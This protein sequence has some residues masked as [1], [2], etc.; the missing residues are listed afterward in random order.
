MVRLRGEEA[1]YGDAPTQPNFNQIPNIDFVRIMDKVSSKGVRQKR[2]VLVG[3]GVLILCRDN[4]FHVK[5]I[6][7]VQDIKGVFRQARP[8]KKDVGKTEM[9]VLLC[10]P[11][12]GPDILLYHPNERKSGYASPVDMTE[13]LRAL[14]F[15]K[16]FFNEQLPIKTLQEDGTDHI[17]SHAYLLK[18]QEY[19]PPSSH[20][21]DLITALDSRVNNIPERIRRKG[22]GSPLSPG[23]GGSQASP[24]GSPQAYG[25]AAAA[26]PSPPSLSLTAEDTSGLLSSPPASPSKA[27]VAGDRRVSFAHNVVM[28]EDGAEARPDEVERKGVATKFGFR[29]QWAPDDSR[30]ACCVCDRK[31]TVTRRRHH[32]RKCGALVCEKCSPYT[33]SVS[34]YKEKQRVCVTCYHD[35]EN[36]SFAHLASEMEQYRFGDADDGDNLASSASGDM[37]DDEVEDVASIGST[38]TGTASTA[39]APATAEPAAADEAQVAS[40]TFGDAGGGGGWDAP[41]AA[42]PATAAQQGEAAAAAAAAAAA[43]AAEREEEKERKREK[44]REREKKEKKRRKEKERRRRRRGADVDDD[45]GTQTSYP[46]HWSAPPAASPPYPHA[47][48]GSLLAGYPG[49]PSPGVPQPLHTLLGGPP[50]SSSPSPYGRQQVPGLPGITV[51]RPPSHSGESASTHPVLGSS[52]LGG[53]SSHSPLLMHGAGGAGGS[54]G[55]S[56]ARVASN[57]EAEA[58]W[59]AFVDEFAASEKKLSMY[60]APRA[61]AAS[62]LPPRNHSALL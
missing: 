23:G 31:F 11:N 49:R 5:R 20:E 12:A 38:D 55:G 15:S 62:V 16:S 35:V 32:C 45:E 58:Y 24:P 34:G 42:S 13:L 25:F 7:R 36:T 59:S 47:A 39:A 17:L 2:A 56:P 33:Q 19:K 43:E 3:C 41:A 21:R 26:G 18:P 60:N 6:V 28:G 53:G 46:H 37:P 8:P 9:A 1:G 22:S 10:I 40:P 27:R 44:K 51:S 57:K 54:G 14:S 48:Y 50:S 30:T 29:V 4:R 52:L 61:Q